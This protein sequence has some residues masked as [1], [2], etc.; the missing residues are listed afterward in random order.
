MVPGRQASLLPP[1]R[2]QGQG[3]QHDGLG[4]VEVVGSSFSTEEEESVTQAH[5]DAVHAVLAGR[6]RAR[7]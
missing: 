2:D 1:R 3:L 7:R 4:K 5:L 6:G